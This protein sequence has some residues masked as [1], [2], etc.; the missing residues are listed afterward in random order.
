MSPATDAASRTTVADLFTADRRGVSA[1]VKPCQPTVARTIIRL[2]P[3][4]SS[5]ARIASTSAAQIDGIVQA[6][7]PRE[8]LGDIA[9]GERLTQHLADIS[10]VQAV[11]PH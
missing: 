7:M 5:G 6:Q 10:S 9:L 8:A 3:A 4:S 1:K 2:R 11:R